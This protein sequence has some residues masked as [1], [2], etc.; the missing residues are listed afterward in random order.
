[1]FIRKAPQVFYEKDENFTVQIANRSTIECIWN[2]ETYQVEVEFGSHTYIYASTIRIKQKNSVISKDIA[3]K[4][5][6]FIA[7]AGDFDNWNY[8]I[9]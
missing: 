1:M 7:K 4:V 9:C 8:E 5:L 2:G 3:D 6:N